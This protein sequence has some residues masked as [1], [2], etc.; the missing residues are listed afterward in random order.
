MAVCF[1]RALIGGREAEAKEGSMKGKAEGRKEKESSIKR[2]AFVKSGNLI[3]K[4]CFPCIKAS[5][6]KSLE[7]IKEVGKLFLICF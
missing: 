4:V 3:K 2:L 6:R 5:K 7:A 1:A